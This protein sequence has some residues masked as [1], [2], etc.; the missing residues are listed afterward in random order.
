MCKFLEKVTLI[1][2][3]FVVLVSSS[4]A[5]FSIETTDGEFDYNDV[6][7]DS[8][9]VQV[10]R[11]VDGTDEPVNQ[12]RLD[13]NTA[14]SFRYSYNGTFYDMEHL[15]DGFYFAEVPTNSTGRHV[16]YELVDNSP[17]TGGTVNASEE[18]EAGDLDVDVNSS[19]SG[20][21]EAGEEVELRVEVENLGQ[22][23]AVDSDG[24]GGVTDG[25]VFVI[26]S[27]GD[28]T[29]S[30]E[31]DDLVAGK[32]PDNAVS[33]TS[34]NPWNG[35]SHPVSLN[36]ST[37]GNS[38]DDSN[39]IIVVDRHSGGTVSVEADEVINSGDDSAVDTV[40]GQELRPM[41]EIRDSVYF[42]SDSGDI[43]QGDEVVYDNDTD[44]IYTSRPD[45]VI[46]GNEPVEGNQITSSNSAPSQMELSSYDSNNGN[47][48]AAGED[49]IAR[50]FD[51]DGQY[52]AR[53][54]DIMAGDEPPEG[55]NLQTGSV[56]AWEDGNT[57]V[58]NPG[59]VEAYDNTSG[60]DW[61]P[62]VDAIWL[63][64]SSDNNG[65]T[66]GEDV[67][68]AGNPTD[69]LVATEPV[70]QFNQWTSVSAYRG[71]D[72]DQFDIDQ[73][74]IIRDYRGGGT[75]SE[76]SDTIVTGSI[77]QNFQEGTSY[78][79]TQGFD[80]DWTLDVI[81][82]FEQGAWDSN[83]DTILFDFNDGGTY[84]ERSDQIINHGGSNDASGGEELHRLNSVSQ[85]D[86][87]WAD[88]NGNGRYDA[89][90]EIFRDLDGD[91]QY[92]NQSDIHLA[93][94]SPST[95]G[96]GTGL[97]TSNPWG[98]DDM[99]V[100]FRNMN[101]DGET[102][103]GSQD[104]IIHDLDSD[105]AFTS[106]QDT[107][108]EGEASEVSAGQQLISTDRD[109][110]ASPDVTV[111]ITNGNFSTGI[112]ELGREPDGDFVNTIEIP[113]YYGANMVT[114]FKAET[115][116]GGLV[117]S[118]SRV[119]ET[120]KRGIGF[121]AQ[122]DLDFRAR[123]AGI[124][125]ENITLENILDTENEI[126][127]EASESLEDIVEF[128]DET[129]TIDPGA[130]ENVS[131]DFNVTPAG[132]YSGDI[133]FTENS[134]G[135]TDDTE[136]DIEGP[137]CIERTETFCSSQ[138]GWMNVTMEERGNTT[139]EFT[140]DSIWREDEAVAVQIAV[141]GDIRQY[142]SLSHTDIELED[143]QTVTVEYSAQDPGVY[144]GNIEI[145]SGGESLSIPVGLNSSVK[146]LETG[147]DASPVEFDFGAVPE[148]NDVSDRITLENTGTLELSDFNISSQDY[149]LNADSIE[150]IAPGESTQTDFT[151]EEPQDQQGQFTI[152]ASSEQQNVS[153]I[154]T[155][156]MSLVTP[157]ED[158]KQEIRD[159]VSDLRRRANST[160]VQNNLVEVESDISSIQT[161]W[162]RGD[163]STAQETYQASISELNSIETT[164]QANNQDTGGSGPS[165]PT[166]PSGSD[167]SES[168]GAGFL[169][170]AFVL[171]LLLGA[172]FVV[173]TSYYPEEGDPLYEVLGDK[174]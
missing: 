2:L 72:G 59:D 174:E 65:F 63:E 104:S 170:F 96:A 107:I 167:S 6:S 146:Q 113:E 9:S 87:M 66:Q 120:R 55:A 36:D 40:A 16:Y 74:G 54:D 121:E 123:R 115:P 7:P 134:T 31:E 78:T 80:D 148:G 82:P 122:S 46:V 100:L 126:H 34:G 8:Q 91:G 49:L 17:T 51:D 124:Y 77:P 42:V 144:T 173:Y 111:Y 15:T 41:D 71:S 158:M 95:A 118:E 3:F 73:D 149:S 70:N 44:G 67:A 20:T 165:Q 33:L 21:F 135:E 106:Q 85:Q 90:D 37:S 138:S 38:W 30:A 141:E 129:V 127:V 169:I 105:G 56:E 75:Y 108:V 22:Y 86:I 143:T 155:V 109:D 131:V 62:S 94:T 76:Q 156:S 12:S 101:S 162:D 112:F 10:V 119:I 157:V 23:Y 39:D 151:I 52:T 35:V 64:T 160:Q 19:F 79:T 68:L 153:Q 24:S 28:G 102:W 61:N 27:G 159:R 69:G 132:D 25:D 47:D 29:F 43:S 172:G 136:V 13:N 171:L 164:V 154:F 83:Q 50:D 60:D 14:L 166:D 26:D 84:S 137:T 99:P 140:L 117:G 1:S 168:G 92:T 93:G 11:L 57:A 161:S 125:T 4:V 139:K 152:E 150:S 58:P 88:L 53:A 98:E 128:E 81:N 133:I 147:M 18:L 163:Y 45:E 89:G 110:F 5:V 48:W 103:N 116:R 145:S 32:R 97:Q 142:L 130:E 114:Q